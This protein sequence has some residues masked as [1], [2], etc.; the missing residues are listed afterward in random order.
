MTTT[1]HESASSASAAAS[2][3]NPGLLARNLRSGRWAPFVEMA[4]MYAI[5]LAIDE[6]LLDGVRFRGVAPHPYWLPVLIIT[7]QY[8]TG[9]GVVCAAFGTVLLL[10]GD[11]AVQQIDQDYYSYIFSI[12]Y[13][14]LLWFAAAVILGEIRGRLV[15][16]QSETEEA[17][18]RRERDLE[19]MTANYDRL[20]V[21]NNELELK[22][23]AELRSVFAIHQARAAIEKD[24]PEEV[25]QGIEKAVRGIVDPEAFSL[26]YL[27]GN[28][29]VLKSASGWPEQSGFFTRFESDSPLFQ[30]IVARRQVLN[31][32]NNEHELV[33]ERQGLLAGPLVN[34]DTGQV[35][36]MLKIERLGFL[37]FNAV[38]VEN[39]RIL[40][41]WIGTAMGEATEMESRLVARDAEANGKDAG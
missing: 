30:A 28:A 36:G 18:R 31:V 25:L 11:F 8:G 35:F 29:L 17:L 16:R 37:D 38:T 10:T 12:A 22:V 1:Q 39:F 33:L 26:F 41:N 21:M 20:K 24:R 4:A 19:L 23:A 14:P 13:R 2:D 27:E 15:R 6:L 5:A 40:C 3:G 9:L 32:V 34:T 7:V